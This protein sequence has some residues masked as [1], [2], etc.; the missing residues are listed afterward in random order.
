M[1]DELDTR[2]VEGPPN[3]DDD[4]EFPSRLGRY[5]VLQEVGRGGMGRVFRA[6]DAKLEREVALKVVLDSQVSTE[7]AARLVVEAR[8]MAK[9]AHPN[10]VAVYDV[11]EAD[12][13]DR[14]RLVIAMEFVPGDS[15]R[16]WLRR[17][18]LT[19][20][21]I[22][23]A[24]L[25]AGKGL[26][27]AHAAGILH[28]DFKPGNVLVDDRGLQRGGELRVKVTDFG[29]AKW[30]HDLDSSEARAPVSTTSAELT[31]AGAVLGT[32][33]YMPPEQHADD[34]LTPQADQYA[35]CVALWEAL[36]GS[37]PFGASPTLADKR[38]ALPSWP[39]NDTPKR[40]V[41]ALH[42][43]L[44]VDPSARWPSMAALLEAIAP[45]PRRG[46]RPV[47]RALLAAFAL[48]TVG[49]GV[50]RLTEDEADD[51]VPEACRD[52]KLRLEA[53]WG[54]AKR[55]AV[56]QRLDASSERDAA[57]E[58]WTLVAARL[59]GYANDW[60]EQYGA[61]CR[62]AAT[63]T[64]DTNLANLRLGCLDDAR[65]TF[66]VTTTALA[67]STPEAL[68]TAVGSLDGLVELR[69]CADA[70]VLARRASWSVP[71]DATCHEGAEAALRAARVAARLARPEAARPEFEAAVEATALCPH[72]SFAARLGLVEGTLLAAG[73]TYD[74]AATVL[75]LAHRDAVAYDQR[76]LLLDIATLE[77]KV[78][79]L[80]LEAFERAAQLYPTARGLADGDV[81]NEIDVAVHIARV[82]LQRKQYARAE[83]ELLQARGALERAGL[84]AD[85]DLE[86]TYG[87]LHDRRGELD[88]AG[89]RYRHAYRLYVERIGEF[90]PATL[91]VRASIASVLRRQKAYEQAE[92]EYRAVLAQ[93]RSAVGEKHPMQA[94]LQSN[95]GNL[96]LD[97]QRY[98]E[99]VTFHR[100]ALALHASLL[101]PD[102]TSVALTRMNLGIALRHVK[103]DVEA[104]R[105]FAE[106]ARAYA[107]SLGPDDSNTLFAEIIEGGALAAAGR[108]EE[109]DQIAE[110]AW[111]RMAAQAQ[112]VAAFELVDFVKSYAAIVYRDGEDPNRR[113]R[114]LSSLRLVETELGRRHA[115]RPSADLEAQQKRLDALID[116][117]LE[118]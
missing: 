91:R 109:A 39:R 45:T 100:R 80:G 37:P 58:R 38:R 112:T 75:E 33:R 93:L 22:L 57:Q 85:A 19:Q 7:T 20:T 26:A 113:A 96:L 24:F 29:V 90:H 86:N 118:G 105:E 48:T 5:A 69:S 74:E 60:A 59:D 47:E 64:E 97:M 87:Q 81:E 44:Q 30:L 111:P 106:V 3:W 99:S 116:A 46:R 72:D 77:I 71:E 17:P 94:E 104:A 27:A 62:E 65:K 92:A 56:R 98:E 1:A 82:E 117:A 108:H 103:K 28:R 18:G 42:R 76:D 15:F 61:A 84:P 25:A 107:A 23:E 70:R 73:G 79:G 32:P 6:Y 54:Q 14:R 50:S 115:E 36:A 110:D 16:A 40:I 66:E 78:L 52:A 89:E 55:D 12:W 53:A 83:A 34:E 13:G 88:D 21:A 4:L 11:I 51:T 95:L 2:P 10:V 41:E 9:L 63:D 35:F 68:A 31:A 101:G 8:V 43:G 49:L 114:A 67:H 102:H